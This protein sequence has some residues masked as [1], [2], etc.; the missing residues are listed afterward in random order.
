[1]KPVTQRGVAADSPLAGLTQ[2]G[3]TVL[4]R[5]GDGLDLSRIATEPNIGYKTAANTSSTLKKKLAARGLND[6]MRI[7]IENSGD[8]WRSHLAACC[9][10]LCAKRRWLLLPIM[11][12][13]RCPDLKGRSPPILLKN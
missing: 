12:R 9:V 7:A 11:L 8:C 3:R 4:F 10:S 5:L 2:L 13:L 6:P 1:M